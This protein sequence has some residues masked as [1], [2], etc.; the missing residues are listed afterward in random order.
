MDPQLEG[1]DQ[2]QRAQRQ[3]H[4]V[5]RDLG[6]RIAGR[7][8]EIQGAVGRAPPVGPGLRRGPPGLAVRRGLGRFDVAGQGHLRVPGQAAVH[9]FLHPGQVPDQALDVQAAQR[10]PPPVLLL[11]D[12]EHPVES[13]RRPAERLLSSDLRNGR[14]RAAGRAGP[15]RRGQDPIAQA[16]RQRRALFGGGHEDSSS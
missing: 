9:V 12:A 4:A 2:Q 3:P 8:D 15:Q 7:A 5:H 16:I 6:A 14:L 11:Q 1:P 10:R 13:V